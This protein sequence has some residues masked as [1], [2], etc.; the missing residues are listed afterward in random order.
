MDNTSL[1]N[2]YEGFLVVTKISQLLAFHV[3]SQ[4][5]I[6]DTPAHVIHVLL[7]MAELCNDFLRQHGK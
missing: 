7:V 4:L 1:F 2:D 3:I 5:S 6:N